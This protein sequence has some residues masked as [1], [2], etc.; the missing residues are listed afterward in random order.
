MCLRVCVCVCVCVFRCSCVFHLLDPPFSLCSLSGLSP[1][2]ARSQDTGLCVDG[3][4]TTLSRRCWRRGAAQHRTRATVRRGSGI[5][6]DCPCRFHGHLFYDYDYLKSGCLCVALC[7]MRD[8][9]RPQPCCIQ[10]HPRVCEVVC[11]TIHHSVSQ[12]E[13][14]AYDSFA[15]SQVFVLTQ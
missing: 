8:M 15:R 5:A 10:P 1:L 13:N 3:T 4:H 6:A 14:L 11:V 9:I 2:H 12:N 7:N